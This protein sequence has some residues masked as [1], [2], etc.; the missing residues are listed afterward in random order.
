MDLSSFSCPPESSGGGDFLHVW[1][2]KQEAFKAAAIGFLTPAEQGEILDVKNHT[3]C[4]FAWS[5]R[6]HVD[7]HTERGLKAQCSYEYL[8]PYAKFYSKLM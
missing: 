6:C 1:K 5:G 2:R 3:K 8:S 7:T 4:S